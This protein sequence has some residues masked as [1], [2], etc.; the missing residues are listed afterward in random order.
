[1]NNLN[2]EIKRYLETCSNIKGLSP[3]TIK[4]YKIDLNQFLNYI[5]S[6]D[7]LSKETIVEYIDF[8]HRK[9]K[10]KSATRKIACIKAFYQ[11]IETEN[12]IC[13]NPFHKIKVKHKPATLLPKTIP[14]HYIESLL[15]YAYS[16]LNNSDSSYQSEISLRN[17]TVI[18]LLFSTGMRVSEISNLKIANIDFQNQTIRILGKGNKE[19]IKA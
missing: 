16:E 10:P 8:L 15:R 6:K 13:D 11:Y 7:F 5:N 1:M 14:L 2:D 3:L 12:I 4:A 17:A 18:E 19:R 9:Y